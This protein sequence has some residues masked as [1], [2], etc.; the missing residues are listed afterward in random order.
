KHCKR[1]SRFAT[2]SEGGTQEM[3][4]IP[5]S[6]V[7]RLIMR[8]KLPAAEAFEDWVVEEVLPSIRKAG[9][10]V[11]GLSVS[12]G[13]SMEAQ[14]ILF[15]HLKAQAIPALRELDTLNRYGNIKPDQLER[16]VMEV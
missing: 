13:V 11:D 9:G 1:V 16:V 7:Y 12:D 4:V 8:S 5:E 14:R 6:D 2:P 3:N 15:D 10:Y